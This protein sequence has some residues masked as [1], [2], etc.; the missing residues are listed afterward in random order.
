MS[1]KTIAYEELNEFDWDSMFVEDGDEAAPLA[2]APELAKA[3][4]EQFP[5]GPVLIQRNGKAQEFFPANEP[6]IDFDSWRRVDTNL[7]ALKTLKQLIADN[8]YASEAEQ[9]QLAAYTV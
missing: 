4:E 1:Q 9:E 2:S 5:A 3:A 8:R 7:M 6:H